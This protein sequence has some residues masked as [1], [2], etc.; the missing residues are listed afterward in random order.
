MS[1]MQRRK[2]AHEGLCPSAAGGEW[3]GSNAGRV[4][5]AMP[6]APQGAAAPQGVPGGLMAG[7]KLEAFLAAALTED[8]KTLK[9]VSSRERKAEIK[10]ERL[11]PKYRDYVRRLVDADAQHEC[12]GYMLVWLLDAGLLE[13]GLELARWC[14]A[15]GHPLPGGFKAS[16]GYFAADAVT[17]WAENEFA[18]GRSFEPYLTN[19]RDAIAAANAVMGKVAW[20]IP[21]ALLA[22][23]HRL[24]GL[25]AEQA[26]N[27]E[28]AREELTRALE[29]GAKVKTALDAVTKKLEKTAA[30]AAPDNPE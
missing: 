11:I 10:R 13:E 4:L 8:L 23:M 5:A 27:L 29:M 20:N 3:S 12:I 30:P 14:V 19:L 25:A 7:Q 26:G 16:A 9:D 15:A 6:S 28:T 2:M 1:L 17:T 24:F 22:R 18:A 21:D